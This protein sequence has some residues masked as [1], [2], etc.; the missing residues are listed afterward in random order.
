MPRTC[1]WARR[2]REAGERI[3]AESLV[4]LEASQPAIGPDGVA[5]HVISVDRF[6]NVA[7]DLADHHLPATGLR[8]GR[9]V[10]VEAQGQSHEAMFTLTFADVGEGEL[11]LYLDSSEASRWRSTAAARRRSWAWPPATRSCCAAAMTAF[12]LPRRHYR[13]TDST[14]ERARELALAGAPERHRGHRGGAD[15]GP[16][17]PGAGLGGAARQGAAVFGDPAPAGA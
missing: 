7:L 1:R 17:P 6:G 13:V 5:A 4:T 15:L 3:Q 16:R 14:N 2:C 9:S 8:M 10:A 12:G 11:L